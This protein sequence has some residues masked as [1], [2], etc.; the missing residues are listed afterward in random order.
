MYGM[1]IEQLCLHSNFIFLMHSNAKI[2]EINL[3]NLNF[4]R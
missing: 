4:D 2:I 3:E 1:S